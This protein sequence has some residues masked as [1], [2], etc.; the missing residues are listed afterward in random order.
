M[1][2]IKKLHT[3]Y[4]TDDKGNKKSVILP[5]DDF[6]ELLEDIEDLAAVVERRNEAT[7][8]HEELL[9]ELKENGII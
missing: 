6:Q 1:I 9:R 5:I 3:E 7:I 2:D 4:I 8:S